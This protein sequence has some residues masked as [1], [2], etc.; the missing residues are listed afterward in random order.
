M[1]YNEASFTGL[2]HFLRVEVVR[3]LL[4][5]EGFGFLAEV[6]AFLE[7]MLHDIHLG[8]YSLDSHKLIG[9]L[10]AES[11]RSHEV[12]A[13]IALE[14]DSIVFDFALVARF[15]FSEDTSF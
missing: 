5:V 2:E 8:D 6:H 14:A 10:A 11:A 15:G 13:Q 3:V 12:G 1:S 7:L 9:Q 4:G